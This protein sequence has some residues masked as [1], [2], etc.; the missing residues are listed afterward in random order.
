MYKLTEN[1]FWKVIHLFQPDIHHNTY[2]RRMQKMV[3]IVQIQTQVL[4]DDFSSL[5]LGGDLLMQQHNVWQMSFLGQVQRLF[6]YL[7]SPQSQAEFKVIIKA[8][9]Y[10]FL[11]CYSQI[12]EIS[13]FYL[14]IKIPLLMSQEHLF[15]DYL[16]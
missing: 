13:L 14:T 12:F 3:L 15:L 11:T 7:L 2:I 16:D 1:I 10:V 8:N 5:L 9:E 4:S 6:E